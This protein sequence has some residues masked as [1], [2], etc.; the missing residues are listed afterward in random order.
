MAEGEEFALAG[1]KAALARRFPA[2]AVHGRR[3]WQESGCRAAACRTQAR[4]FEQLGVDFFLSPE[5]AIHEKFGEGFFGEV[6]V[7]HLVA[8]IGAGELV[9][10]IAGWSPTYGK[11]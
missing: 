6:A 1:F 4:L 7:K 10:S 3:G 8:G 2:R 11:G 9:P 5:R